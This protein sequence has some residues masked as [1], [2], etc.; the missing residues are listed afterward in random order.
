MWDDVWKTVHT[1]PIQT[2]TMIWQQ[3]HLNFY[4][5][6]S[7]NKW[8]KATE[9]CPLCHKLPENIY[10]IMLHC[11]FTNKLWEQIEPILKELHPLAVTEEE[12]AFGLVQKKELTGVLLRNWIS[13]LLR[14]CTAQE[15]RAAYHTSKKPNFEN[16]KQKFNRIL[17][18]EIHSKALRYKNDNNLEFFEK[19]ITHAQTLCKI[20]GSGEYE[21]RKVFT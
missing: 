12:K 20:G 2:K 9:T 21:I 18:F 11:E 3:I 14:E 4:T 8:H 19:I 13:Y 7:Y 10:H 17:K 1:N 15:E 6:Y 16:M 5:Q